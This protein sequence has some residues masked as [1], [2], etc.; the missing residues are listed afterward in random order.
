MCLS[1]ASMASLALRPYLESI[2]SSL[3]TCG[4]FSAN[5]EGAICWDLPLALDV[6]EAVDS[7]F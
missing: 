3:G 7:A 2:A 5:S 6:C 4:Q 1:S